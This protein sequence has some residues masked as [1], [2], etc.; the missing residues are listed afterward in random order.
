MTALNWIT[1]SV[2]LVLA[3]VV[4]WLAIR[5]QK[6]LGAIAALQHRDQAVLPGL[7]PMTEERVQQIVSAAL[8]VHEATVDGKRLAVQAVLDQAV[9]EFLSKVPYDRAQRRTAAMQI[10][11]RDYHRRG[12]VVPRDALDYMEAL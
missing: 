4:A 6:A 7:L 3:G 10:L 5:L 2:L 12:A 1:L 8:A 11:M 9:R